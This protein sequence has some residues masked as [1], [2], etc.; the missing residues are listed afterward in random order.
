MVVI[1]STK[2][3]I[4]STP[5]DD[6]AFRADDIDG[7]SPH[8]Q[9]SSSPPSSSDMITFCPFFSNSIVNCDVSFLVTQ[10][11]EGR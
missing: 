9:S 6:G 10:L 4:L 8:H 2:T 11:L 1:A 3:R 7:F 5:L